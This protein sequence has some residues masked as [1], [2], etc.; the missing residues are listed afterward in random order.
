MGTFYFDESIHERG[1]FIIGA[2]VFAGFDVDDAV[3][4]ALARH[5][6]RPGIDEYKSTSRMAASPT[7]D[8]LRQEMRYI[9]TLCSVGLVVHPSAQRSSLCI[10]AIRALKQFAAAN[11]LATECHIVY[12]DEGIRIPPDVGEA[13]IV[14]ELGLVAGSRILFDSNSRLV[15]G[16]QLADCAAHTAATVLLEELGLVRKEM[17]GRSVDGW[18][19][20]EIYPLGFELWAVIRHAFFHGGLPPEPRGDDMFVIIHPYGLYIA[21]ECSQA[22]SASAMKRF[23]TAYLGCIH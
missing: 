17:P 3:S 8:S 16:L 4:S 1:G 14:A 10:S 22:L 9:L 13:D 5:G 11:G 2:F 20:R 21:P 23:G 6:L 18:D 15:T 19:P 12:I 7:L